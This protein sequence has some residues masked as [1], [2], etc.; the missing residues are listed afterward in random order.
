[1]NDEQLTLYYYRDGLSDQ[2]LAD[3]ETAL[4]R[5]PSLAKRY[6]ALRQRLDSLATN[7][8]PPQAPPHAM[9]RWQSALTQAAEREQAVTSKS[10]RAKASTG[11]WL[12]RLW[13]HGLPTAAAAV[14]VLG[15]GIVIG[16]QLTGDPQ[17]L[18]TNNPQAVD[19]DG[20]FARGISSYLQQAEMQLASLEAGD[21]DQRQVLLDEIISRNRLYI[22]AAENSNAPELARVL[23]AFG[24]VLDSLADPQ[25]DAQQFELAK[26][27]LAFEL[28]AMQTKLSRA[29]SKPTT[30]L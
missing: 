16:M 22:R 1:M 26:A 19:S 30:R 4:A 14:L 15:L 12:A 23:R 18:P 6:A 21:A 2:E 27:Q 10:S 25:T 8:Q 29:A 3:V 11:G 17:T 5:D 28:G 13:P 9:Q 7:P 20:S 24:P